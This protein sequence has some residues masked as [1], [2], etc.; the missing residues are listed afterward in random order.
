VLARREQIHEYG[1]LF[2]DREEIFIGIEIPSTL[3]NMLHKLLLGDTDG[4]RGEGTEC[5]T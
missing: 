3:A 4:G 1:R 5:R 2:V